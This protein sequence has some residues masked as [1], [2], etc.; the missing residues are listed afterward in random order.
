MKRPAPGPNLRL[1]EI[2]TV[3]S[4][5]HDPAQFV[6]RYAP[7]I[8][9]YLAAL[10]PNR[11]DREEVAQDFFLRVTQHG[12]FRAKHDRG[13]FRDY[14]KTAVRNAARNFLRRRQLNN[15]GDFGLFEDLA[16]EE[17]HP[18][19]EQ[20]WLAQWRQCLLG[21]ACR[22]LARH[23]R[24]SP[25]NLFFTVLRI[26]V[27][28]PQEDATTL[29][30]RTSARIGRPIRADAFRKQLSRARRLLAQLLLREVA[31]TLDQPTPEHV[32]AE[33]ME[34]DLWKYVRGYLPADWNRP[35]TTAK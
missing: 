14:V 26:S 10:I 27:D 24:R 30:A 13:R 28:H 34:V 5:V 3:W 21:R 22:H 29:A 19:A 31:Q 32:Q 6:L 33:L 15:P 9:R 20:V 35:D 12:F 17:A 18:A 7:A 25:G 2:S 8:E 11:H 1:N 4:V 23:E 16:S